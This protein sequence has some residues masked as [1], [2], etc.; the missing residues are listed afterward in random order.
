MQES[1]WCETCRHN[2]HEPGMCEFCFCGDDEVIRP[3]ADE[4]VAIPPTNFDDIWQRRFA[5]R[6]SKKGQLD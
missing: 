3:K 2:R 5:S 6:V 1:H 4:D